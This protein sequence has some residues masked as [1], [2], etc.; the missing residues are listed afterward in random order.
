MELFSQ[1]G[2][3]GFCG[4]AGLTWAWWGWHRV[5]TVLVW[6]RRGLWLA[7]QRQARISCKAGMGLIRFHALCLYLL[8]IFNVSFICTSEIFLSFPNF[9]HRIAFL[10]IYLF[11]NFFL[12]TFEFE[13]LQSWT[14]PTGQFI[15]HYHNQCILFCPYFFPLHTCI[16]AC[17]QSCLCIN[18]F[19]SPSIIFCIY[20]AMNYNF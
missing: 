7:W 10:F 19:R 2:T 5:S 9:S 8:Y 14:N 20:N 11:R 16:H 12:Y 3:C 15:T 1:A 18:L 13:L 6:Q 4:K 17:I